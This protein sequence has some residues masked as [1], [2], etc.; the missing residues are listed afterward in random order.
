MYMLNKTNKC[1]INAKMCGKIFLI[2]FIFEQKILSQ[3]QKEKV[4]NDKYFTQW[5]RGVQNEKMGAKSKTDSGP[6]QASHLQP[7]ALFE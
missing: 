5:A 1:Q 4:K 7:S 6:A 3:N 2:F